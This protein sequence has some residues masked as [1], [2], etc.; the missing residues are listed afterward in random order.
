MVQAVHLA[1]WD[2]N[3]LALFWDSSDESLTGPSALRSF[4]LSPETGANHPSK[5]RPPDSLTFAL[6]P[7]R[8]LRRAFL[9]SSPDCAWEIIV[10]RYCHFYMF[11]FLS[12]AVTYRG[13][14]ATGWAG[15]PR[16]DGLGSG[17]FTPFDT[18]ASRP[19][20]CLG[21]S[22]NSE[23]ICLQLKGGPRDSRALGVAS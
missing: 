3:L 16:C 1:S 12:A 21:H 18:E 13:L 2:L 14:H 22:W 15:F 23:L 6:P 9:R 10:P 7:T 8:W 17:R 5:S 19:V 11:H 20:F 4:P